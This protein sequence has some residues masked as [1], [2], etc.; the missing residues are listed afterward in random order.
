M[1][2]HESKAEGERHRRA[3]L[4][5][6]G[7]STPLVQLA[8][9]AVGLTGIAYV[10]GWAYLRSYFN[11]IGAPWAL[12]LVDATYFVSTALG[13]LLLF[14]FLLAISLNVYVDGAATRKGAL[15]SCL[16][17]LAASLV[18]FGIH[19]ALE[20]WIFDS[21]RSH[22]DVA[23]F[24]LLFL[25][26]FQFFIAIVVSVV[27]HFSPTT[28]TNMFSLG[29]LA[30]V[31]LCALAPTF[32]EST[33]KKELRSMSFVSVSLKESNS[34]CL[35]KLVRPLSGS[36]FL[37]VSASDSADFRVV[38]SQDIIRIQNARQSDSC[39]KVTH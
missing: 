15:R 27:E 25:A 4:A 28:T 2:D 38:G 19:F 13:S 7:L 20:R 29:Y 16:L 24:A 34:E 32:A 6:R 33:A 1:E 26:G 10:A 17:L 31:M 12:H 14:A 23:G 39:P 22:W 30:V 11:G 3:L 35:W 9:M 37:I 21:H 36:N 18:L 5:V 8:A